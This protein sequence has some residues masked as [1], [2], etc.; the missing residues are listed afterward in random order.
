MS[1]SAKTAGYFIPA[2]MSNTLQILQLNAGKRDTVMH[3]LMNDEQ[4]KD[5]GVIIIAEPHAGTLN[6]RLFTSPQSHRHWTRFLPT[7]SKDGRWP[8]RSMLWIRR[9]IEVE[10]IAIDSPDLTAAILRLPGHTVL[11]VS[12]YIE[13]SDTAELL[14]AMQLIESLIRET[15]RKIGARI[16]IILAGDFNRHDQLWGGNEI[17][18]TRQGEADP[19]IDLMNEFSLLSLLPR[20]TKTWQ[21]GDQE[22]TIELILASEELA[23]STVQCRLHG[24]EYGSDHRAIKTTFDIE[25]P[26]PSTEP[27]LLFKNAP[28]NAIKERISARLITTP[29]VGSSQQQADRLMTV[30]LE[31]V[32]ALTPKAKPSPYAKRW[33]TRDLTLL[34]QNYTYQR[35]Q[36]RA[37]RRQGWISPE[38]ERHAKD[39]AK[40]YHD[41]IKSQKRNHWNEFLAD[42]SNIWQAAK[43]LK[44]GESA[45]DKIPPLKR[46]DHTVT[47]NNMEQATELLKTFFP[48]LPQQI[49]NEG[50]RPQRE[51]IPMPPLTVEEIERQIFSASPWKAPG[52]DAV[53][54][55]VQFW[56]AQL[57]SA[58]VRSAQHGSSRGPLS[59]AQLFK[60]SAQLSSDPKLS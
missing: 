7:K 4:L 10:Q 13:G 25:T 22:S 17:A 39:A 35:N 11:V 40:E 49:E 29:E 50:D 37:Q 55:S 18:P 53:L 57:S 43:Y 24:T 1:P 33:W 3:S 52:E 32:H 30:T 20:G 19:I 56:S 38:L 27:R 41:A 54:R 44:A 42:N 5:F 16:D 51:A 9:D 58:P 47:E 14:I 12:V 59:S 23:S 26:S 34:R 48:P 36:A 46:R 21:Q 28:W 60:R 8:I 6:G 2:E 45:F 31:A 15:R